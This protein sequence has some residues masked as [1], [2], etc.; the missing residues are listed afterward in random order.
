MIRCKN[1][2]RR[3]D[4]GAEERA[5]VYAFLLCALRRPGRSSGVRTRRSPRSAISLRVLPQDVIQHIARL[6][7][8]PRYIAEFALEPDESYAFEFGTALPQLTQLDCKISELAVTC[9]EFDDADTS[10]DS[11]MLK[12]PILQS[13]VYV[14]LTLSSV[15]YGTTVSCRFQSNQPGGLILQFHDPSDG[16][17]EG[18]AVQL[19]INGMRYDIPAL[20]DSW[21]WVDEPVAVGI[22]VDL[23]RG[24]VTFRLNEAESL[25]VQLSESQS[26]WER[27]PMIIQCSE[28]PDEQ[29][30][31]I[32]TAV[33][34]P[35][36]PPSLL[37][38]AAHPRSVSDLFDSGSLV[39]DQSSERFPAAEWET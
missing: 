29:E 3:C 10:L 18:E 25:C 32:Q 17:G 7:H 13:R 39:L 2:V 27:T 24:C 35:P 6:S 16:D 20:A 22:L 5:T 26:K 30:Q 19:V 37:R 15:W 34:S 31:A 11:V 23:L 28:F 12:Q 21:T 9:L 1:L 36:C 8:E 38:T 14:E 4:V 33:S